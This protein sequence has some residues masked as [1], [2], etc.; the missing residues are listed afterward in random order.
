MKSVR[1]VYRGEY[2]ADD[3]R[4]SCISNYQPMLESLEHEI[5]VQVDDDGYSGDSRLLLR[6]FSGHIGYLNFGWGS[7]SG[8]DALQACDTWE[9]VEGLRENLSSGIQWFP[10]PAAALK[11]FEGHDWEGD[12]SWGDEG[13]KEFVEKAKAKL[14]ELAG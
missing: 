13:Q 5:L 14:R 8:C 6:A 10:A 2:R 9:A 11:F 12:Y 7:C 1:E 3:E 4:P